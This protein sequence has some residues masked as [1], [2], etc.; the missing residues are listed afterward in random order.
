MA[1]KPKLG[2]ELKLPQ[3]FKGEIFVDDRGEL[4]FINHLDLSKI[5]RFYMV[6]NHTPGFIRA[7]HGHLKEEK[8][9]LVLSG[10]ALISVVKMLPK[11]TAPNGYDLFPRDDSGGYSN[12]FALNSTIPMVLHIPAGYA[13]GFKLLTPDTKLMIWSTSTS[14]QSAKDDYRF[15]ARWFNDLFEVEER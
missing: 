1:K 14:E 2:K 5:K 13:N 7:W 12:T 8:Y 10:S 6:Q 4:G 9:F 3:L 11:R 15:P